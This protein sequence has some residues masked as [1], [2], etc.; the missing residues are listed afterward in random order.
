MFGRARNWFKTQK[1]KLNSRREMNNQSEFWETQNGMKK[2]LREGGSV[3]AAKMLQE[4]IHASYLP[5][6][7]RRLEII[8]WANQIKAHTIAS[9][10]LKYKV[11]EIPNSKLEDIDRRIKKLIMDSLRAAGLESASARV[12]HYKGK[13]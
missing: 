13:S 10:A 11:E 4:A 2:G 6:E 3:Q 9:E 5:A 8:K 7:T 12:R 1:F